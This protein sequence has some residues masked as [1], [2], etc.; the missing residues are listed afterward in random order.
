LPGTN[1]VEP[2]AGGFLASRGGSSAASGSP[3]P[4][5]RTRE[6]H[7]ISKPKIYTYG[8]IRY[9]FTS[10]TGEPKTL[11]EAL[12]DDNWRQAMDNEIQALHKNK[13]WHLVPPPEKI[14]VID[15]KW[16]YKVKK[17]SDGSIDRYKTR[18]VVKGFKQ[19]YG[20]TTRT[21]L[22]LWSRLLQFINWMFIMLSCMVYLKKMF[23]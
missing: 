17:K 12:E 4:T 1:S 10:V 18:L 8:T 3:T 16:V 21:L 23:S 19:R 6:Q 15:S 22:V 5:R 20:L 9:A 14:N 7:D 11:G 13:T 2:P